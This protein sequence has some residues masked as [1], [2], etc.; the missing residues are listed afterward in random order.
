MS[1]PGRIRVVIADDLKLQRKMMRAAFEASDEFLL[2]GEATTGAELVQVAK[3]EKPDLVLTDLNMPVL[4]GAHALRI[5]SFS[6]PQCVFVVFSGEEDIE[7]LRP[8][9]AAGASDF[10]RKPLQMDKLLDTV[11]AIYARE[12]PRKQVLHAGAT[13]GCAILSV[14]GAQA[15]CGASTMAVNLAV[16][17]GQEAQGK[18]LLLDFDFQTAAATHLLGASGQPGL[19]EFFQQEE[20]VT[21]EALRRYLVEY[22][23]I[24][25]LPGAPF[26]IDAA[27]RD[28]EILSAMLDVL[29][30]EFE[31]IVLDLEPR[32]D[33]AN[34]ILIGRSDRVYLVASNDGSNLRASGRWMAVYKY[35]RPPEEKCRLIYNHAHET[36]NIPGPEVAEA[37]GLG[38]AGEVIHDG[39]NAQVAAWG[40]KPA[41]LD[42]EAPLSKSYRELF[43]ELL[44]KGV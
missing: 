4:D 18:V 5:L 36:G 16:A 21:L 44:A 19:L 28:C 23:G 42:P 10:L 9:I 37:V 17:L 12:A 14:V 41:I 39:A 25:V 6:I 24:S 33:E 34:Q 27:R 2:V 13:D 15:G 7:K 3:R 32:M 22:H 38:V 40:G 31:Y 8:V 35:S 43:E 26:P 29:A 30:P 1:E 11:S 20:S